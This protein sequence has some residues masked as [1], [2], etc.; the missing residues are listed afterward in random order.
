MVLPITESN[1]A[2]WVNKLLVAYCKWLTQKDGKAAY[3]LPTA[4]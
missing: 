4:M 2:I 1:G 3:R